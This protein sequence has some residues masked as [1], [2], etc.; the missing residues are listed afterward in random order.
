MWKDI[1]EVYGILGFF[2]QEPKKFIEEMKEKYLKK[3]NLEKFYIEEKI[4]QRKEAKASKNYEL[5]DSIRAELD[6][7]GIIL[8]DIVEGTTWDIKELY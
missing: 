8:N 4:T 7:K 1:A 2:K 5:A 3:V 6:E